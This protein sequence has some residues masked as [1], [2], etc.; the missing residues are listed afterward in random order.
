MQHHQRIHAPDRKP[1]PQCYVCD[2]CPPGSAQFT[3][4]HYLQCHIKKKHTDAKPEFKCDYCDKTF[5]LRSSRTNHVM[6]A[7]YIET[8]RQLNCDQCDKCFSRKKRLDD[9]IKTVH[10]G[11]RYRCTICTTS[12]AFK[13]KML[14]HYKKHANGGDDLERF[15]EIIERTELS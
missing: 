14:R 13:A 7:H 12:F 6:A 5:V 2:I 11:L 10:E 1:N 4:L 9:H 15:K 8:G 3:T